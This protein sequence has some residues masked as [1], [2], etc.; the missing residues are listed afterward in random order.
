MFPDQ[1]GMFVMG[2]GGTL[3]KRFTSSAALATAN[4]LSTL[5]NSRADLSPLETWTGSYTYVFDATADGVHVVAGYFNAPLYLDEIKV[6]ELGTPFDASTA[7]EVLDIPWTQGQSVG[8]QIFPDEQL[9]M[10]WD[11]S[12]PVV[13]KWSY[14]G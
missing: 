5:V 13:R 10:T 11:L 1:K 2:R 14:T 3:G 9:V 4:N 6:Y 12:S 8:I 7:I